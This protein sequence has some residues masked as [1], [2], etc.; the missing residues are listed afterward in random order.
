MTQYARK[1]PN[2]P[3]GSAQ[4]FSI[5]RGER[6]VARSTKHNCRTLREEKINKLT[7]ALLIF[8]DSVKEKYLRYAGLEIKH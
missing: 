4:I 7:T 8:R 3:I 5:V 2:L 1:P 6:H